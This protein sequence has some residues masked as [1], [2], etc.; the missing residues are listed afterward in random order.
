MRAQVQPQVGGHLVVA[1]A[2]GAQLAAERAEPIDQATFERGVHVFVGRGRHECARLAGGVEIGQRVE[3]AAELVSV[4]QPGLV[5][6]PGVRAR[7]QQVV[8]R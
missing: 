6:H 8:R 2:A 3:H 7:C 1:A 5:Q 4:E